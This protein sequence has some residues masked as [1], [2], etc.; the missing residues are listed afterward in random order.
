MEPKV[1]E[2]YINVPLLQG[3]ILGSPGKDRGARPDVETIA[4]GKLLGD[5]NLHEH[6]CGWL[7]GRAL[8]STVR[9]EGS[10]TK[11]PSEFLLNG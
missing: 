9:D 8:T 1:P 11:L 10:G 2:M 6:F 3:A 7:S 5:H 4:G